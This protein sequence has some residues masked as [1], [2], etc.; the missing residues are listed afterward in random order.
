MTEQP[1]ETID[2]WGPNELGFDLW[3]DDVRR[4]RL[5]SANR[6]DVA[7][8]LAPIP[9][10]SADLEEVD[11]RL[12]QRFA[13]LLPYMTDDTVTVADAVELYQRDTEPTP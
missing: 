4:V 11:E 5:G 2:P 3:L 9:G 8:W 6:I 10:C 1:T 7:E 12:R 13:P